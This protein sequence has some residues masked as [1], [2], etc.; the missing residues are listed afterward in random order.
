MSNKAANLPWEVLRTKS[1]LEHPTVKVALEQIR[2]P[3]GRI[4][5][6]WPK[7]YTNDY[8]N[9]VVFNKEGEA[10]ILEGYKH[11]TGWS[12]WQM[13]SRN[14]EEDEDPITAVK[15]ELI[16]SIGFDTVSWTYLGSYVVDANQHIGV[17]HFFCARN[18]KF[19]KPPL[20]ASKD[21]EAKW[22]SQDEL[23]FALLD[24]RIATLNYAIAVS[25]ALL[26]VMK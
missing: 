13:V 17:G 1:V 15:Q 22:V 19:V 11:G 8:V 2:L 5:Q 12:S 23:R 20:N 9:A 7:I 14:L 24:G 18:A 26:T 3:D 25:L 16:S 10:L 21:V 6:D 4:I